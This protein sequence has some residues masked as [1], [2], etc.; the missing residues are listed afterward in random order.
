[1]L[2]CEQPLGDFSIPYLAEDFGKIIQER[3]SVSINSSDTFVSRSTQLDYAIPASKISSL[4]SG[5]FVGMVADNPD[6]KIELKVFHSEIQNDHEAIRQEEAVYQEIPKIR[7]IDS[8]IVQINYLQIKQDIQE[9]LVSELGS[10]AEDKS[11]TPD[12]SNTNGGG[13]TKGM[14][15]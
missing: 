7:T 4:S 14:R 8:E 1:M 10:A 12:M 11:T 2:V 15:L 3:Q 9:L 13:I 5:E 6:S